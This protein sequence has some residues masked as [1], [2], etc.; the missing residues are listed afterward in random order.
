MRRTSISG[1]LDHA[2]RS[3]ADNGFEGLRRVI[4]VSGDG[5]NNLGRPVVPARDAAL[6]EGIVVNGLPLM[7]RDG[8]YS[9]FDIPDLDEYYRRC[10]I[11]GPAAFVVP[12]TRWEEFPAA[13]RQKLVQ[14]L[15]GLPVL[16]AQF[17]LTPEPYDCEVGEKMWRQR[18]GFDLP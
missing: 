11:G 2:V 12:V 17:Q 3:L 6:A 13:V 15:V 9:S 10:V 4:D 7:T 14:E 8:P 1:A 18:R 16:R 5:P